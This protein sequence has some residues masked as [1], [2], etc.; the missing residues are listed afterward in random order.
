MLLYILVRCWGPSTL[1]D[2]N[3][4]IFSN[5]LLM[6]VISLFP[7]PDA[8]AW[9]GDRPPDTGFWYEPHSYEAVQNRKY[10]YFLLSC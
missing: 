8:P 9:P 6:K 10:A 2:M 7:E 1:P 3:G 4:M 5:D